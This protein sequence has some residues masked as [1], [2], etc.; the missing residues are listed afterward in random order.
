MRSEETS[1][2]HTHTCFPEYYLRVIIIITSK[3]LLLAF[4]PFYSPLPQI[5]NMLTPV[6]MSATGVHWQS[7]AGGTELG[8]LFYPP[9]H[10]TA[11]GG[12]RL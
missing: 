12:F 4:T 8:E 5:I 1:W 9:A 2:N 7:A 10:E 6:S 11:T 3:V